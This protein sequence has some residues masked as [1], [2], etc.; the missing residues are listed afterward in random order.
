MFFALKFFVGD[1]WVLG[2]VGAFW[3]CPHRPKSLLADPLPRTPDLN[4]EFQLTMTR[5][6]ARH[7]KTRVS[8]RRVPL[9]TV[10]IPVEDCVMV[11]SGLSEGGRVRRWRS[12]AEKRQV[13]QLTMEAGASVAEVAREYGLNANQVFKW[14]RAF[15][16][17][18]V[19]GDHVALLPV[20]VSTSV[21]PEN[22]APA[23]TAREQLQ[24]GGSIHIEL[25][26]R[27]VI[28]VEHGGDPDLVRCVVQSVSR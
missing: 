18:E 27:A 28:S 22:K 1:E 19:E 25:H 15:E 5:T 8:V 3:P 16:R 6:C 4:R 17:G 20:T 9:A 13:V 7:R 24:V 2:I 14:R 11:Q 10:L 23:L 21:M 26:G 12:V